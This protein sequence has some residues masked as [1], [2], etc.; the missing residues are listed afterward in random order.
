MDF[1][2]IL[3]EDI[4]IELGDNAHKVIKALEGAKLIRDDGTL[5]PKTDYIPRKVYN[6]DKAKLQTQ[7]EERTTDLK[8]LEEKL[9]GSEGAGEKIQELTQKYANADKTW[10]E[11]AADL[12]KTHAIE[13]AL[14]KNKAKHPELLKTL[15][16]KTKLVEVK[17]GE[18]AGIDEQINL[19]KEGSYKDQFGEIII[20]GQLPT[21]SKEKPA[22]TP[23]DELQKEYDKAV[24]DFGMSSVQAIAKK[25]ELYATPQ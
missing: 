14:M 15:I 10:K 13:L 21:D 7:L 4:L 19:L 24:K 25:N 11:Q 17:D 3:G 12:K 5:V 22:R 1:K 16:D 18:F 23:R 20:D 8:A 9:K 2:E 6:E